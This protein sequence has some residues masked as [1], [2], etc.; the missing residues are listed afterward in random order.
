MSFASLVAQISE[1]GPVVRVSIIDAKGSTP[2][3]AGTYMNV[4]TLAFTGT[5]GGGTLEQEALTQARKLLSSAQA[6]WTRMVRDYPLGPSLGQCCG[7]FIKLLFEVISDDEI[8]VLQDEGENLIAVRQIQSG[9]PIGF[10]HNRKDDD[11]N[12]PLSVRH[13]V[14]ELQSGIQKREAKLIDGWFIE[15]LGKT[16]TPLFLYGAGHVG[17]AVVKAFED[18][19]FA[20]YWVDTSNSRYPESIPSSINKLV[21]QTPQSLAEHAPLDAFHVV[22]SYSHNLDFEICHAVLAQDKFA[23][24]GVIASKTKR[25]RFAKRLKEFAIPEHSIARMNAPIGIKGLD[26]KEPAIIALSLA[27]DLLLRLQ[28]M[29]SI[30]STT[31]TN[32]STTIIRENLRESS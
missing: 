8:S 26:G 25:V 22:M 17:R 3:E 12:W 14:R 7:G 23:Y 18:L 9:S 28:Q 6:P 30:A 1:H 21:T 4:S 31:S 24:L 15:P 16:L 27:A 20:I 29:Q 5:I 32:K 2:R 10:S 13:G 11:K 19:P